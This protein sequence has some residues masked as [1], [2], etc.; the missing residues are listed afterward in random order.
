[1][2]NNTNLIN[3]LLCCL[4]PHF[5]L[6]CNHYVCGYNLALFSSFAQ[7]ENCLTNTTNNCKSLIANKKCLRESKNK[8]DTTENPDENIQ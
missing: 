3:R 8:I 5:K 2:Q 4:N 1:M 7:I 6:P